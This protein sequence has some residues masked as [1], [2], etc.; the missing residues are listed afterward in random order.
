MTESNHIY[1]GVE[2]V[3]RNFDVMKGDPHWGTGV[4]V[5]NGHLVTGNGLWLRKKSAIVYYLKTYEGYPAT[6]T[7]DDLKEERLAPRGANA[8]WWEK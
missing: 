4:Y 3:Q 2:P 8:K 5:E 7:W 6:I 1:K